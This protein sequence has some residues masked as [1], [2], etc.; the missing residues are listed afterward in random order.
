MRK[1]PLV[2]RVAAAMTVAVTIV[3]GTPAFADPPTLV[4]KSPQKFM[5]RDAGVRSLWHAGSNTPA[6][7]RVAFLDD[8]SRSR[9]PAAPDTSRSRAPAAPDTSRS[10]APAAP[11]TSPPR[12]PTIPDAMNTMGSG[13]PGGNVNPQGSGANAQ[14]GMAGPPANAWS[15]QDVQSLVQMALDSVRGNAGAHDGAVPSHAWDAQEFG[16]ADQWDDFDQAEAGNTPAIVPANPAPAAP[17][18]NVPAISSGPVA[19]IN[20]RET[21]VTL[22]FLLNGKPLSLA[23]GFRMELAASKARIVEFDRGGSF[24]SARYALHDGLYTFTATE[25]GWELYRTEYAASN[26]DSPDEPQQKFSAENR[27]DAKNRVIVRRRR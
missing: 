4:G 2:C 24:D 19:I 14:G 9:A 10:R 13:S 27:P 5:P 7:T 26:A 21:G 18:S 12:I 15:A 25:R 16:D 17:P 1:F 22:Q 3:V 8:T 23:S 11:D 6:V 20:P